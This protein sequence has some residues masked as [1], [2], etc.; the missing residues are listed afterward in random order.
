[1]SQLE[2]PKTNGFVTTKGPNSTTELLQA[3]DL[4]L[5]ELASWFFSHFKISILL[6]E[7][8]LESGNQVLKH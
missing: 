2:K 4:V 7:L 8:K 3:L 6:V 5:K 1:M